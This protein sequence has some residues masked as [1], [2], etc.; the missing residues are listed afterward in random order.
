MLSAVDA[1]ANNSPYI[2]RHFILLNT[3][4]FFVHARSVLPGVVFVRSVWQNVCH[5]TD[6]LSLYNNHAKFY[7]I[8]QLA[9]DVRADN[10]RR[11]NKRQ[12]YHAACAKMSTPTLN[13]SNSQL[14]CYI[15]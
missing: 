6:R 9:A 7:L 1:S 3:A 13:L 8:T 5:V 15:W 14:T 10:I 12:V 2:S 11:A 4:V